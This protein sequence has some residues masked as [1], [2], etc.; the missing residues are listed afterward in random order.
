[1]G[2]RVH[3]S[4]A[5]ALIEVGELGVSAARGDG[6]WFVAAVFLNHC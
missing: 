6:L 2:F 4:G 5:T 1:M 3:N